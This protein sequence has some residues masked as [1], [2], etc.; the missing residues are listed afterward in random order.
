MAEKKLCEFSTPTVENI[1]TRPTLSIDDQEFELKPSLI[2]MVQAISFSGKSYED[3]SVHLQNFL[4]VA[5]TITIKDIPDDIIFLW[6]FPFS[7]TERARQ[8]FYSHQEEFTTW[9]KC[10]NE[11]LTRLFPVGKTNAL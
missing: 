10:S 1:R 4:E 11:F 3:A 6:L 5:T 9:E 8:W 7:L 2:N